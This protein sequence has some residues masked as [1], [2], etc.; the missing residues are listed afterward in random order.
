VNF[1]FFSSRAFSLGKDR[2]SVSRSVQPIRMRCWRKAFTLVELLV[3]IA[4]I[5]ILI[6]LLL[7][8]IQSAREAARRTQCCDNLKNL[9]LAC[10]AYESNKKFLPPGKMDNGGSAGDACTTDEYS[11]WAL[12]ILPYIDEVPLFRLYHFDKPND[13]ASNLPVLQAPC[14]LQVCPS[15]P[16]PPSLQVPEV[17]GG[18]TT[19]MTG[20]YRGVAGRGWYAQANP[21]EAYW[22]S[23]KATA[24]E[25]M[26]VSDRGALPVVVTAG[27]QIGGGKI[28]CTMS[29][30][31]NQPVKMKQIT[32]GTSKSLIIGEYTTSTQPAPNS[33]SAFWAHSTF[34]LNLGDVN[35]PDACRTNPLGCSLSIVNNNGPS[36]GPGTGVTLDPDY[37]KCAAWTYSSFPQPCK[38]T[39]TGFHGGG[40]GINFV[41]VDGSVHRLTNTMDI[42]I[43][44]AL[45][46]I[47]G[48][49]ALQ[50]VP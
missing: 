8:A 33:R 42:R 36:G 26:S 47:G 28:N 7:P 17:I 50:Q 46:T 2:V 48:G 10:C 9:G 19:Y 4:I 41:Y 5:G 22:D 3:V 49:E 16:N 23:P 39:F 38:R 29:M 6:A 35:L 12:E 44:S 30:L 45:A 31:S 27:G 13:D 43:L 11:N 1:R 18:S 34:G 25:R 15:D 14:K 21:A 20:S 40:V 37:N 32:D 24:S